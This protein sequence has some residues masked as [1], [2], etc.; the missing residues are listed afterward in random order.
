MSPIPS[1]S[2]TTTTTANYLQVFNPKFNFHRPQ[3]WKFGPRVNLIYGIKQ[4][5]G[6][7][8]PRR[9]QFLE[10]QDKVL[11]NERFKRQN[12]LFEAK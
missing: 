7:G 3:I 6:L 1:Y 8:C 4:N 9:K 12:Y 5:L 11:M 2:P 10:L